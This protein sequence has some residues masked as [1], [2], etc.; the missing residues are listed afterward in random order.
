MVKGE[1]Y[2]VHCIPQMIP[3]TKMVDTRKGSLYCCQSKDHISVGWLYV[4][5]VLY[6]E[7]DFSMI[8]FLLL[9][10]LKFS[11]QTVGTHILLLHDNNT[12]HLVTA[13]FF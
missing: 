9:L 10:G 3:W 13:A 7:E 5:E 8:L 4:E 2:C 1:Y 6:V 11:P 12:P